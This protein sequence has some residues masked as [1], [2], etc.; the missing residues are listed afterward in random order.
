M[1]VTETFAAVLAIG[2]NNEFACDYMGQTE[3][4][5]NYGLMRMFLLRRTENSSATTAVLDFER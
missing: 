1:Y 5:K 3:T 4:A 2:S